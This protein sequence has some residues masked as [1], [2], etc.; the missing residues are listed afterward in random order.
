MRA[1]ALN[2]LAIPS[3]ETTIAFC[4]LHPSAKVDFLPFVDDFYL[5]T[6]ITFD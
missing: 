4:L 6:K 2:I 1:F 5:E 3:N